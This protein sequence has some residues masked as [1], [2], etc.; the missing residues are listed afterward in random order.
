MSQVA[1]EECGLSGGGLY[2]SRYF[3]WIGAKAWQQDGSSGATATCEHGEYGDYFISKIPR[4]AQSR[5]LF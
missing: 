5:I 2:R 4:Q 1:D 3:L